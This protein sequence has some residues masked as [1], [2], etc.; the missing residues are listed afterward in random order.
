VYENASK[1]RYH[2]LELRIVFCTGIAFSFSITF[3]LFGT[4][5]IRV[6]VFMTPLR[7]TLAITAS[8]FTIVLISIL[9]GATLPMM[10][11]ALHIDPAH[12]STTIQVFMDILGV[13]ITVSKLLFCY[14]FFFGFRTISRVCLK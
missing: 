8:L 13:L 11:K 3:S 12:S 5:L 9:L 7:E 10:M 2:F 1:R 6:V 4:G 14:L